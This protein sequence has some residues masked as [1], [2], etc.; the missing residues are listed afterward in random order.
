MKNWQSGELPPIPEPRTRLKPIPS[1]DQL[2]HMPSMAGSKWDQIERRTRSAKRRLEETDE[3]VTDKRAKK[4]KSTLSQRERGSSAKESAKVARKTRSENLSAINSANNNGPTAG[5]G[6]S[7][8]TRRSLQVKNVKPAAV[9]KRPRSVYVIGSSGPV[10]KGIRARYVGSGRAKNP[11]VSTRPVQRRR[12]A[13]LIDD[14]SLENGTRDTTVYETANDTTVLENANDTTVHE[15]VNDTTVHE[16]ANNTNGHENANHTND[17]NGH[18]NDSDGDSDASDATQTVSEH[19]KQEPARHDGEV[20][21]CAVCDEKFYGEDSAI[22]VVEHAKTHPKDAPRRIVATPVKQEREGPKSPKVR[23]STRRARRVVQ[24][25]PSP[26]PQKEKAPANAPVNVP[27][28]VPAPV[29][30][31]VPADANADNVPA[32]APPANAPPANAPPVNAPPVNAPPATA[33]ATAAESSA[34]ATESSAPAVAPPTLTPTSTPTKDSTAMFLTKL[35]QKYGKWAVRE[36]IDAIAFV[37]QEQDHSQQ[38]LQ[39]L[40]HL[41]EK[42]SLNQQFKT[43]RKFYWS[44]EDRN[45]FD[46]DPSLSNP[47]LSRIISDKHSWEK[48]DQRRRY[49]SQFTN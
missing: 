7:T 21:K 45:L 34:P 38:E 2:L 17:T 41:T 25:P 36:A 31:P 37:E 20:R 19:V 10:V 12:R 26:T 47:T 22:A 1:L 3:F 48:I 30:A 9:E 15:N 32:N 33:P 27:A 8:R 24:S 35:R 29:S 43:K 42:I 4:S 6:P 11:S 44:D 18:A 46:V 5:T 49:L 23:S 28:P 16:T 14:S 13:S 40:W 39:Y